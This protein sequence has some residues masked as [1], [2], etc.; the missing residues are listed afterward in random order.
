MVLSCLL[1]F[2]Y[3]IKIEGMGE[4]ADQIAQLVLIQHDV[5]IVVAF[6]DADVG[7]GAGGVLA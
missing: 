2:G 1:E 3:A 4:T 5:G 7:Q 6:L